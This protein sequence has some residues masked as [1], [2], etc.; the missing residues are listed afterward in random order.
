MATNISHDG[1]NR[2][3]QA[4]A[5]HGNIGS[6]TIVE[7]N[8]SLL[9]YVRARYDS[10]G[11][12]LFED[13]NAWS[14]LVSI[15]AQILEDW[16][17]ETV[18]LVIDASYEC[19]YGR[20]NLLDLIVETSITHREIKWVISSR[21]QYDITERLESA[22]RVAPISLELNEASVSEAINAFIRHK[23]FLLTNKKD[24][25]PV[26]RDEVYR[27][28]FSNSQGTFLWVALVWKDLDQTPRRHVR[29][30]LAMFPPRLDALYHQ[31]MNQI[32]ES[33]DAKLCKQ[34]LG[35]LSTVYRPVTLSE[36]GSL[37]QGRNGG[38]DDLDAL[39]K[40]IAIW[41][42]S[43]HHAIFSQSLEVVLKTLRRN[44]SDGYHLGITTQDI[45]EHSPNLLA[46]AGY[47]CIYWVDHLQASSHN[48]TSGLSKDDGSRIDVFLERKYLHWLEFLS[49]LGRVSHGIQSMQKLENLIQTLLFPNNGSLWWIKVV[50]DWSL[51]ESILDLGYF[52]RRSTFQR[53]IE[54]ADFGQL[55]LLEDTVTMITFSLTEQ[56]Q[57]SITIRDGYQT[58]A[59]FFI[60]VAH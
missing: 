31:M 59:N 45:S 24:Y 53:F 9:R 39:S 43:E 36:L 26:T 12:A 2:G 10:A 40:I 5:I 35:T 3:F 16:S 38:F 60:V 8:R 34:I 33:E 20:Q 22:T 29:K 6:V 46:M 51:P 19:L 55:Q 32:R 50:V 14:V 30:K 52:Q 7:S 44:V 25:T 42:K 13:N 4:G 48:M 56:S 11:K 1:L 37:L 41:S 47:A 58:T 15:C 17:L 28:L 49:I 23:V 57:N 18:H 27:H 54:A 21:N